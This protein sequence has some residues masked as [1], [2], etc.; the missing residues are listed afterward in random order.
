M[1]DTSTHTTTGSEPAASDPR[2]LYAR[3]VATARALVATIAADELTKPTPCDDKDVTALVRHMLE[4]SERV[5]AL[6]AG[7]NPMAID[8]HHDEAAD[9]WLAAFGDVGARVAAAWADDAKLDAPMW[10]PW[11]QGPGRQLLST[12]VGELTTHTWDLS[13]ALGRDAAWD[14]DVVTTAWAS[15]RQVFPTAERAAMFAQVTANFPPEMQGGPPP[16]GDGI[17]LGEDAPL[18]DRVAAWTGRDPEWRAA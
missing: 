17:E 5:V 8:D 11:A 6:G 18:V 3:A 12:Y 7:E 4:G 13:R 10:L 16:F 14:D 1:T 9:R 15:Y 2:E